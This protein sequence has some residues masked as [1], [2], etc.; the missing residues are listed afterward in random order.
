MSLFHTIDNIFNLTIGA[1]LVLSNMAVLAVI[2]FYTNLRQKYSVLTIVLF[3]SL[4]TGV[5]S[6]SNILFASILT[7]MGLMND[8]TTNRRCLINVSNHIFK[9]ENKFF[10]FYVITFGCFIIST[11]WMFWHMHNVMNESKPGRK[12]PSATLK[13]VSAN[14]DSKINIELQS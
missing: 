6:I 2:T 8:T 9:Y 1:V 12:Q 3:N 7:E 13:N 14:Y 4:L 11:K 10:A 5:F